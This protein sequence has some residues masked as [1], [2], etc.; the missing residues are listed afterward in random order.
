MIVLG[1]LRFQ[2]QDFTGVEESP[3][4]VQ[5]A[6]QILEDHDSIMTLGSK[7]ASDVVTCRQSASVVIFYNISAQSGAVEKNKR[8]GRKDYLPQKDTKGI[9]W[10]CSVSVRAT[11]SSSFRVR[12]HTTTYLHVP[13]FGYVI[14]IEAA[15]KMKD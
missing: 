14:H 2:R 5:P 6:S 9:W 11:Q 1:A 7:F 8:L 13:M 3:D 15:C 10:T 4:V 12:K